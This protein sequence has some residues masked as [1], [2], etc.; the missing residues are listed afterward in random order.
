MIRAVIE[1][2]R[3]TESL[4]KLEIVQISDMGENEKKNKIESGEINSLKNVHVFVW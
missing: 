1:R 2:I 4:K 3:T